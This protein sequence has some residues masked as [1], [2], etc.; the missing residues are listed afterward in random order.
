MKPRLEKRSLQNSTSLKTIYLRASQLYLYRCQWNILDSY[1]QVKVKIAIEVSACTY[2][3]F[4]ILAQKYTENHATLTI[5]IDV[6]TVLICGNSE[7]PSS[8]K[9]LHTERRT[10]TKIL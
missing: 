5:Q 2:W 6:I 4:H 1:G 7:A 9:F 8:L 3:A 10:R